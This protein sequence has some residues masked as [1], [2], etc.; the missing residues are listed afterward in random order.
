MIVN[1]RFNHII[2]EIQIHLKEIYELKQS[3][4]HDT[5]TIKRHFGPALMRAVGSDFDAKGQ[6]ELKPQSAQTAQAAQ[7]DLDAYAEAAKHED[8]PQFLMKQ[9]EKMLSVL[10]AN[11]DT[12]KTFKISRRSRSTVDL[13]PVVST[14]RRSN[15]IKMLAVRRRMLRLA[16]SQYGTESKEYA[17]LNEAEER[18]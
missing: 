6:V 7:T 1:V 18:V 17:S 16:K 3:S 11:K 13:V 5:Y 14:K 15:R 9:L 2:C 12:E 4:G 8:V 10:K